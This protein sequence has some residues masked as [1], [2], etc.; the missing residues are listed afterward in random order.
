VTEKWKK[1]GAEAEQVGASLLLYHLRKAAADTLLDRDRKRHSAK[2]NSS[3][4]H[5]RFGF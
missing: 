3:R 2:V 4:Q 5:S 1:H